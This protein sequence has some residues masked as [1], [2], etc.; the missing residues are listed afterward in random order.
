M[1]YCPN[2]FMCKKSHPVWPPIDFWKLPI[3]VSAEFFQMDL[4]ILFGTLM[5]IIKCFYTHL[6]SK[7]SVNSSSFQYDFKNG[8]QSDSTNL[9]EENV[10]S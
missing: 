5:N 10:T 1:I 2:V 3:V 4:R 9:L 6:P 7:G 8:V